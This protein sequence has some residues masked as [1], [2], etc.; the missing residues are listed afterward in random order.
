MAITQLEL[1]DL[2]HF[3]D[4]AGSESR[5]RQA[6]EASDD[7]ADIAVL[8]TQVARALGLQGRTAE[9]MQQLLVADTVADVVDDESL[10][11]RVAL[12]RG[13]VQNSAGD[14]AAARAD[15]ALALTM[16]DRSR[17]VFLVVDTMHM[18]A[19][20]DPDS[21]ERVTRDALALL[22]QP[23]D[24]RT[25]RWRV[26]LWNTLGWHRM[27]AGAFESAHEAFTQA[28]VAAREVG[29]DAQQVQA[30]EAL[31]ECERLMREFD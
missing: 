11:A 10:R 19:I 9:A 12:E 8:A 28:A 22:E 20:V 16:L 5:L 13:R 17:D 21:A 25:Q 29:T 3:T 30:R 7:P 27:D 2:W 31:D 24:A 1:D 15:F 6:I 18:I 23:T 4:A 26:S 14:P